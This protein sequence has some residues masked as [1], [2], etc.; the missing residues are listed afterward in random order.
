MKNNYGATITEVAPEAIDPN[1]DIR[2]TLNRIPNYATFR[3]RHTGYTFSLGARSAEANDRA[4]FELSG[5]LCDIAASDIE[6]APAIIF[7]TSAHNLLVAISN[8]F[9]AS[10]NAEENEKNKTKKAEALQL[11][12]RL[13]IWKEFHRQ[14]FQADQ[15]FIKHSGINSSRF[16]KSFGHVLVEGFLKNF[17]ILLFTA[18]TKS[19][20]D[21][22]L[23]SQNPEHYSALN[24][25]LW[26]GL[27]LAVCSVSVY[28]IPNQYYYATRTISELDEMEMDPLY[29]HPV[30]IKERLIELV[31]N[32]NFSDAENST[33]TIGAYFAAI[34]TD[35]SSK[36]P[37]ACKL[38]ASC[39]SLAEAS[40]ALCVAMV[41]FLL[42]FRDHGLSEK[43]SYILTLTL[44]GLFG[45][46]L[47]SAAAV[48]NYT[49]QAQNHRQAL[50]YF[51]TGSII[52]LYEHSIP[53]LSSEARQLRVYKALYIGLPLLFGFVHA[54]AAFKLELMQEAPM[55][56]KAIVGILLSLGAFAKTGTY[57]LTRIAAAM[58]LE[59][60]QSTAPYKTSCLN[61][62]GHLVSAQSPRIYDHWIKRSFLLGPSYYLGLAALMFKALEACIDGVIAPYTTVL[63]TKVAGIEIKYPIAFVIA[64][65]GAFT[66]TMQGVKA[67]REKALEA[68][69]E[70]EPDSSTGLLGSNIRS[71]NP[72]SERSDEGDRQCCC[73]A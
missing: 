10:E 5:F 35:I 42:K 49:A 69:A 1:E 72:D 63:D 52:P 37:L 57:D 3:I 48:S 7:P 62:V 51:K 38:T 9:T 66:Q 40:D 4:I 43:T 45:A 24:W 11:A 47:K 61:K 14:H 2:K 64:A 71:L 44:I 6:E 28:T 36:D 25:K 67:F 29:Y 26:T 8:H 53:L 41:L 65:W 46:T 16:K 17:G 58:G 68:E 56:V 39:V 27:F 34:S 70:A 59:K 13:L 22:D 15:E 23:N 30:T 32:L 60:D 73:L 19:F 31:S 55:A 20:F 54:G 50:E 18:L 21:G 12:A 33:T